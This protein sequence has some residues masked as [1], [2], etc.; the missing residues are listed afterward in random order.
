MN[1][2]WFNNLEDKL[3]NNISAF[4]KI[5]EIDFNNIIKICVSGNSSRVTTITTLKEVLNHKKFHSGVIIFSNIDNEITYKDRLI[6]EESL[7]FHLGCIKT[8]SEENN[9]EIGKYEAFFL[10]GLNFFREQ[11]SPIII[12]EDAFPFIKDIEYNYYLDTSYNEDKTIFSYSRIDSKDIYLYKS[13]LCSFNYMNFDYD[14]LNYGSFNALPYILG[15]YFINEVYPEIKGKKIKKIVNDI[16]P[17][18]IYQRVNSNPRVILNYIV[19]ESGIEETIN[20]IK[21]ITSRRIIAVSNIKSDIVNNTI[22][23]VSEVTDIINKA[24]IDD[25]VLFI[26]DKLFVK[27]IRRFFIK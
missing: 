24:D 20:N 10:A 18:L 14:V 23:D 4:L 3:T 1:K 27:E 22:K 16:N 17:N 11:K 26:F 25:I 5:L 7:E 19:D 8:I 9:L 2:D 12:I 21:S 13:E 6:D 15:I